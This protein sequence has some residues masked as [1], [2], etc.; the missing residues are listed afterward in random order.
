MSITR[1]CLPLILLLCPLRAAAQ[2]VVSEVAW[3][4]SDLSTAD[5]WFELAP[6]T[7]EAFMAPLSLSGWTLRSQTSRGDELML[8]FGPLTMTGAPLVI[9]NYAAAQSRLDITPALVTTAVALPNTDLH[10]RLLRPDGSL[11]DEVLLGAHPAGTSGSSGGIWASAERLDPLLSGADPGNWKTSTGSGGIDLGAPLRGSPNVVAWLAPGGSTAASSSVASSSSSESSQLSDPPV[12]SASGATLSESPVLDGAVLAVSSEALS[13]ASDSSPPASVDSSSS[14]SVDSSS[15]ASGVA[16]TVTLLRG[17]LRITEVLADPLGTDDSE[18]I[19]VTNVSDHELSVAGVL[20]QRKGLSRS[21][22]FVDA[23]RS[24]G[25]LLPG[26][27]VLVSHEISGLTLPNA[28]GEILLTLNGEIID[29][30]VY[31]SAPEGASSGLLDG[32]MVLFCVPT[33][34]ANNVQQLPGVRL[35]LQGGSQSGVGRATVNVAADVPAIPG[36][37]S[38]VVDFG[39][40][41]N[42]PSCN[43]PSHSFATPGQYAITLKVASIC[44]ELTSEPLFVS[45]TSA[46]SSAASVAGTASSSSL[47]LTSSG[48]EQRSCSPSAATGV[49]LSGALPNPVGSDSEA[50]EIVLENHAEMTVS[51]CGWVLDDGPEGSPAFRLDALLMAAGQTLTLTR[52]V[53]GIALNNDGDIIRL[54][55]PGTAVA[56]SECR[57][58]RADEGQRIQCQGLQEE[59]KSPFGAMTNESS[60]S[61]VTPPRTWVIVP[62]D[63]DIAEGDVLIAEA[64]SHP[65]RGQEEWIELWNTSQVAVDLSGWMLDD[66]P[67]SGSAP[68]LIP[69]G[70]ILDAGA[71]LVLPRSQT[72]LVLND[73][74]DEIELRRGSYVMDSVQLPALKQG[75]AFALTTTDR[76]WCQTTPPTPGAPTDVCRALPVRGKGTVKTHPTTASGVVRE[77]S[78]LASLRGSKAGKN[79]SES[80]IQST[81]SGWLAWG[82]AVLLGLGSIAWVVSRVDGW[83]GKLQLDAK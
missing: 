65:A 57:Y 63:A 8:A 56:A 26:Q 77:A 40:G 3:A 12:S 81:S 69:H 5:E 20:L 31:P 35:Q 16:D 47:S 51:L 72:K 15:S 71:R 30:V 79:W 19:E 6:V 45:V 80:Q 17:D 83:Q 75:I 34:R 39:D 70:T 27:V 44:G 54:F 1:L 64:V 38:C 46:M 74:G 13:S 29:D 23:T 9:S 25:S 52:S 11:A 22:R 68:W 62:D 55:Q 32:Q 76:S 41:T 66:A 18:W 53:T 14:L 37:V 73:P 50:E 21:F 48:T 82:A 49:T 67:D 43:P 4:G 2:V 28:G 7:P 36:D 78:L 58:V 33:P 24:S 42:S 10:L 59:E 60:S 61:L